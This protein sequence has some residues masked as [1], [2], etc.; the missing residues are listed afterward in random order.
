MT[1]LVRA[2]DDSDCAACW[3]IFFRAVQIG[4]K[5]H[6]DQAQRDAWCP[7]LPSPTPERCARLSRADTFVA[8]DGKT[9]I[10]FMSLENDGHL[11]MAFVAPDHMGRG[12]ATALHAR[13]LQA[14]RERGLTRLVT[15]ASHLARGM[16]ARQGWHVTA[17]ETVTR[18]GVALDRF[19]MELT[20]EEQ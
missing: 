1:P 12:V 11:D 15:E 17:P 3:G 16:F 19:R 4:A 7:E 6:Y 20:L 18:N 13:V 5:G 8:C 14:A 10:G 2:Y 9:V